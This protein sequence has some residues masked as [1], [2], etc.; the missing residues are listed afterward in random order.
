MLQESAFRKGLGARAW[1]GRR[2]VPVIALC[3]APAL[4][5]VAAAGAQGAGQTCQADQSELRRHYDEAYRLEALGEFSR[6][7]AEHRLFL[8]AALDHL[9][10]GYANNGDYVRAAPLYDEALALAP[11]DFIVL[12]DYAGAAMDSQ[13]L[14]RAKALLKLALSQDADSTTAIQKADLHRMLGGAHLS[15]SENTEAL[16]EF[17]AAVMLN[18]NL[19]NLCSLGDAVLAAKGREPARTMFS[20]IVERFGDTAEIHMRIGRIYGVGRDPEDAITEFKQAIAE[21][22]KLAGVHYSLGA[23]YMGLTDKDFIDAEAEFRKELARHP[24]DKLSYPQLAY[25]A[26]QRHDLH[27]AEIDF[28]HAVELNPQDSDSFLELGKIFAQSNRPAEAEIAL[29]KAIELA[30]DPARN[31]YT[32]A[33]G[34]YLLG[35]LLIANGNKM[36]GARELQVSEDLLDQ[37]SKSDQSLLNRKPVARSSLGKIRVPTAEEV[38]E[39]RA[40]ADEVAPLIAGGYN[41]LGVHAAM[42]GDYPKAAAYFK[43]AAS[44]NPTLPGVD[45]NWGRAAFAANQCEEAIG[46]LRRSLDSHPEDSEVHSM[47]DGCETVGKSLRGLSAAP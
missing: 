8:A 22:D 11:N 37:N 15:L 40:F 9:A 45:R 31:H 46:P 32:I 23:A 28:E 30:I 27:E 36:E 10:D 7:D 34:H 17:E 6:A 4:L 42:A 16:S 21:D 25:I 19:E 29:R 41:N 14:E 3:L 13:D 38:A 2:S 24:E 44:W 1:L 39:L 20:K 47:L 33:R 5:S 43:L 12:K 35:R 26:Q 18:P